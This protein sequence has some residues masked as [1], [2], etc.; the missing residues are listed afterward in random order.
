[1]TTHGIT[2]LNETHFTDGNTEPQCREVICSGSSSD[3]HVSTAAAPDAAGD[4]GG[5]LGGGSRDSLC[6]ASR[7]PGGH[8]LLSGAQGPRLRSGAHTRRICTLRPQSQQQVRLSVWHS[9]SHAG[10]PAQGF[11]EAER[12]VRADAGRSRQE[13]PGLA[14]SHLLHGPRRHKCSLSLCS[15]LPHGPRRAQ[16]A[17]NINRHCPHGHQMRGPGRATDDQVL[18]GAPR[19]EWAPLCAICS[20]LP[21]SLPSCPLHTYPR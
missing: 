17:N 11:R 3:G 18:L 6:G 15:L 20:L 16:R 21:G 1:M 5:E 13:S 7:C 19:T 2:P 4:G 9:G 10:P 14:V 8:S 12:E